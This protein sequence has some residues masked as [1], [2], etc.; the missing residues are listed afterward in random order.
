VT[1][2]AADETPHYV[3]CR[4]CDAAMR[5]DHWEAHFALHVESGDVIRAAH[6]REMDEMRGRQRMSAYTLSL[7]A[8]ALEISPAELLPTPGIAGTEG[9]LGGQVPNNLPDKHR[10]LV[11]RLL[12]SAAY[13][14][15]PDGST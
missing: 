8:T 7:A 11:N 1:P 2:G 4:I 9:A 12:A 14:G 3:K 5:A 6:Q 15:H 10:D 13:G